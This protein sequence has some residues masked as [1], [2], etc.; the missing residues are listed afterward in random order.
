[1]VKLNSPGPSKLHPRT[2][3]GV[4]MQDRQPGPAYGVSIFTHAQQGVPPAVSRL[5]ALSHHPS[6][7]E[8]QGSMDVSYFEELERPSPAAFAPP[9]LVREYA[10][11]ASSTRS[12]KVSTPAGPTPAG[13]LYSTQTP[14]DSMYSTQTQLEQA[15]QAEDY[16]KADDL[17]KQ[18]DALAEKDAALRRA[19]EA[20]TRLHYQQLGACLTQL[21]QALRAEDYAKAA[22]LK[23]QRDAL[24]AKPLPQL[25]TWP[26][27][28]ECAPGA[29]RA[30]S[31]AGP[32]SFRSNA[33]TEEGE[34]GGRIASESGGLG[35]LFGV[36]QHNPKHT[37]Q[38]INFHD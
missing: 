18:R 27:S 29:S 1:M 33:S 12:S 13:S 26:Q 2:R 31:P 20:Q 15:L 24:K 30:H 7:A 35:F 28:D 19:V 6:R 16:A 17:K 32:L 9:A 38:P 23:K 5:G 10:T 8:A 4:H 25:P 36:W 37:P 11:P 21:E 34:K 14:A 3:N 22:E